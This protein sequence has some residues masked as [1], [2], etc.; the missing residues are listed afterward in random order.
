MLCCWICGVLVVG[1]SLSWSSWAACWQDDILGGPEEGDWCQL[2][3]WGEGSDVTSTYPSPRMGCLLNHNYPAGVASLSDLADPVPQIPAEGEQACEVE[4]MWEC[5]W[6]IA[7]GLASADLPCRPSLV[8]CLVNS[9]HSCL[10][11]SSCSL[12]GSKLGA[13]AH[14]P[15]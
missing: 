12:W 10:M 3:C 6:P 1:W 7:V 4:W 13:T 2:G 14:S 9:W 15:L 11:H 8:M 5:L